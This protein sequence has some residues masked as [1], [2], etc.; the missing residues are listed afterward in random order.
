M[1]DEFDE[2]DEGPSPEDLERFSR[3]GGYCPVCGEEIFDDIDYCPACH[4]AISGAASRHPM[5]SWYRRQWKLLIVV[6]LVVLLSG[7]LAL[8]RLG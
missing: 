2:F 7:I 5:R 8:W 4:A 6:G 3:V 1:N